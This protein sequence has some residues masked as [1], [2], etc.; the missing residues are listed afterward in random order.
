MNEQ[1]E[2]TIKGVRGYWFVDGFIEMAAGGVFILLAALILISGNATPTTF[3]AWFFGLAGEIAVVKL[4]GI[5]AAILILWWLKDHFTYPRT[6]FV[7]GQRVTASQVFTVIRNVLL[8]LLLPVIGLLAVCVLFIS[9]NSVLAAM[10]VWF[11]VVLGFVWAVLLLLSGQ[12]MGVRRFR[13]LAA[14][15]LL[16]GIAVGGWQLATGL[17]GLPG[18]SQPGLWQTFLLVCIGRT[19]MSLS[20]LVLICGV[21]LLCSGLATFLR[22]RNENPLPYTEEA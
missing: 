10:P 13:V 2:S 1:I 16:A 9:S 20:Y 8:F 11:P 4:G 21:I 14:L 22:Y 5:L 6:G 19:F 18:A 7:R 12:W 3:S 15:T 17:P